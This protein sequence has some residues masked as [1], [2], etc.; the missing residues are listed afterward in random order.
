M[1][2]VHVPRDETDTSGESWSGNT[3]HAEIDQ[4]RKNKMISPTNT[5]SP[6]PSQSQSADNVVKN[7][8]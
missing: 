3:A 5:S 2:I 4:V 8:H 7:V 6:G 1:Y